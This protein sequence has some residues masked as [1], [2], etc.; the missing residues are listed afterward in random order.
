MDR[1][2]RRTRK[3]LGKALL[4][5]VQEK[6][7]DQITIQDIT[8]RADI[9]RATFYLHYGSKEELLAESLEEYFDALVEQIASKTI[10]KADL[11][12]S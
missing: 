2:K 9:N 11:G 1:R 12:K 5:L 6:K 10:D 7:W 4:E 3:Y 8:D